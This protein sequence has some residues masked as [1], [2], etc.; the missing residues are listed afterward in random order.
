MGTLQIANLV[1]YLKPAEIGKLA[2]TCKRM[3]MI[4]EENQVW[5]SLS[6]SHFSIWN[7]HVYDINVSTDPMAPYVHPYIGKS[8]KR[9]YVLNRKCRFQQLRSSIFLEHSMIYV[10]LSIS[11]YVIHAK[12]NHKFAAILYKVL[13]PSST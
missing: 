5:R 6:R 13:L 9:Q 7:D 12:S 11:R 2:C 10:E 1:L 8:W 4:I 3:S